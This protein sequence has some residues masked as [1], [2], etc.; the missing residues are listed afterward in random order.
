VANT[1]QPGITAR[2]GGRRPSRPG[3]GG[4]VPAHRPSAP[5]AAAPKAAAPKAAH[6][7]PDGHNHL[8]TA[9]LPALVIAGVLAFAGTAAPAGAA[10]ASPS[11]ACTGTLGGLLMSGGSGQAARAGTA[12][13]DP[14]AAEVVDTGGC[15]LS[16]VDVE[17]VAPTSGAG[18]TF[19]GSATTATVASGPDGVATAPSLTAN[20]VSGS[21]AVLAQVPSTGYEAS[22]ALTNT[23]SGVA[24]GVRAGSGNGQSAKV[25]AQFSL[26]LVVNVVDAYGTPVGE[27][28][29]SFTI[30]P[31]NGAGATFVGGGTSASAQTD[32]AGTA[33][34]PLLV[35]GST[36]GTF[37]VQVGVGGLSQPV[38]FTLTDSASAPYAITPGSGTSQQAPLGTDFA[39]PL[40]VTVTDV[41]NNP[42]AGAK[43]TFSAP[44]SGPSGVFAGH[45]PAVAV[46][47]SSKG[48]AVAPNFSA[49]EAAGGYL[50]TARVAGLAGMATFAMVNAARSQGNIANP[51]SYWLATEA[52][53]VLTSGSATRY[54]AP[55]GKGAPSHV[56]GIAATP[57]EHGYWLV[58]K[59]GAVYTYGDARKYG[60]HVAATHLAGTHLAGTHLA[61]THLAGTHLAGTHLAGPVVGMAATP[62]GHGYWLATADGAVYA[63]GDAANYGSQPAT[64][65][66]AAVVAIAAA[67]G[68]EGYWLVS[69]D[70]E[71]FS[72][73]RA[74]AYGST[75]NLRLSVPIVGM[76]ATPQGNGYW[77]V[78]K[79]GGVFSFG[80]ATFYGSAIGIAHGPAVTV[81]PT[82][83]GGGYWVVSANGTVTG[84]GDA[85]SQ[86]SSLTKGTV[87]AGAAYG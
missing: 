42:V 31:A 25:G 9:S 29:V 5:K 64:R 47:T 49:N 11:P 55:S 13:A 77:L 57:D 1:P 12:F 10:T 83:D 45:G 33:T 85:G 63:Y 36:A 56:V 82:S 53:Q 80:A 81:V 79:D 40:A 72:F 35:A 58:T 38:T 86:G 51:G 21:Y 87:V 19:P 8:V 4:E 71:V 39:V 54:R 34:S 44:G 84:F 65:L 17:F 41:N 27:A 3:T 73:G 75:S 16:D 48:V 60:P 14:L 78:G 2:Q 66:N 7:S 62:D 69:K 28:N 22:F 52:G 74:T 32:A 6:K 26:P 23:T 61:G 50:V 70:G 76:A 37:T 67:P 20:Q 59:S 15:P 43:V 24:A 18:G 46:V 68:G 30:I